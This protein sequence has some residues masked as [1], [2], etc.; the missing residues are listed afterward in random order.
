MVPSGASNN[1]FIITYLGGVGFSDQPNVAIGTN[2][3]TPTPPAVAFS[4][5]ETVKGIN[6]SEQFF[7]VAFLG[8]DGG[9]D[10]P[11]LIHQARNNG[12]SHMLIS[13]L[14][15]GN[16]GEILVNSFL[17]PGAQTLPRIAREP[18]GGF[19]VTWQSANQDGDAGGV[20]AKRFD[21]NG[22]AL[23]GDRDEIQRIEMQGTPAAGSTY[24]LEFA[25]QTTGTINFTRNNIAD[26]LAIQTALRNLP[27][28]G[29]TLT[30]R[31]DVGTADE[32]QLI[33]FSQFAPQTTGGTFQLAHAGLFTG[34]I[35]YVGG[36]AG[37][38]ATNIQ[39]ALRLLP[40]LAAVTVVPVAPPNNE[41]QF[42]VTFTGGTVGGL[43]QPL[44]IVQTENLIPIPQATVTVSDVNDGGRSL[45]NF[46]VEF[47]GVDGKA[48]QPPI[49]LADNTGGVTAINLVEV[50]GGQNSEFLVPE[51]TLGSQAQPA[52]AWQP[53]GNFVTVW[54]S[55]DG[56]AN[57]VFTR[58]WDGAGNPLTPEIQVNTFTQANQQT[59]TVLLDAAGNFV[60]FY[61]GDLQDGSLFGIF[62][63]RFNLDGT[64]LNDEFLVNE[65]TIANQ[66]QPAAALLNPGGD[67]VVS[68][69]SQAGAG[70]IHSRRFSADGT[71]IDANEVQVSQFGTPSQDESVVARNTSGDYV[72]VWRENQKDP[73]IDQGVYA[74]AFFANGTPKTGEIQVHQTTDNN[75]GLPDVA[76]DEA[77]N[78]V[79]T[80]QTT[81]VPLAPAVTHTDILARRFN[82]LGVPQGPEFTVSTVTADN[83]T[84]PRIA[85]DGTGR[86]TIVWQSN[87]QDGSLGGIYAR[88]FDAAGNPLNAQEFRVNT[89]TVGNQRFPAIDARAS[90]EFIVVW[91]S[92]DPNTFETSVFAQRFN[93]AGQ[94]IGGEFAV[95]ATNTSF[96]FNERP[97][98]AF[99][100]AGQFTIAWWDTNG[101]IAARRFDAAA[102]PLTGDILVSDTF[103]NSGPR[104]AS[105]ADGRTTIV[106]T[107][108]NDDVVAQRFTSDFQKIGA[109][110][111]INNFVLGTQR[112]PTVEMGDSGEFLVGWI[113]LGIGG[114][115]VMINSL[116][117]DNPSVG[118]KAAGPQA[119]FTNSLP[120]WVDGSNTQFVGSG[121]STLVIDVEP[122]RQRVFAANLAASQLQER[123][124]ETGVILRTFPMPAGASGDVSLAF[125]GNTLYFASAGSS[126]LFELDPADGAIVDQISLAS[127]GIAGSVG[128]LAHLNGELVVLTPGTGALHFIDT[129]TDE[130]VRSL[131]PGL[132]GALAVAGA[133]SRGTLYVLRAGNQIVEINPTTGTVLGTQ[134]APAAAQPATSLAFVEGNLWVGNAAGNVAVVNPGTNEVQTITLSP[135]TTGGTFTLTF[136][137]QT[138]A[139]ISF[140]GTIP[141]GPA[142]T[143]ANIQAA[144][145]NLS[146]LGETLTVTPVSA[147]VFQVTFTGV[148]GGK[149]QPDITLANNSLLPATPPQTVTI[150]ETVAGAA[151]GLVTTFVAPGP[152]AAL[153]GDDGGAVYRAA[154]SIFQ[155]L[156]D[157][158]LDDEAAISITAGVGPYTGRFRPIE[159]LAGFDGQPVTGTWELR[160]EDTATGNTGLLNDWRLIINESAQT[161]PDYATK[162]FL[163][164]NLVTGANDIDLYRFNVLNPSTLRV[165]LKNGATLDGVVRVFNASGTQIGIGNVIG[166]GVE[167]V[168]VVNL[169]AAGD[170]FIGIS[171]NANTAYSPV[172]GSGATGGL[173]TGEYDLEIRVNDPLAFTDNNSTFADSTVF[174][175][176]G[177]IG[178]TFQSQIFGTRPLLN[179]PGDPTEPGHRDIPLAENH[180]GAGGGGLDFTPNEMLLKFKPGTTPAQ[181]AAL[182]ASNGLV[183][184]KNLGG[185][186]LHLR[187]TSGDVLAK[188]RTLSSELSVQYAEPNYALQTNRIPNDP[189]F[190]E[191]WGMNNIGQ[192]NGQ[193]DSDTDA[194]DA[195]D[196]NTGSSNVVIAVIDTG[197][198]YTHPDLVGNMWRNPGE[199]AGDGVDN[200]ANGFIDDVFGIDTAN[201]DSDPFDNIDHGTH[202]AGTIGAVGDNGVGVAGVAWDVQI[203]ALKFLDV[204]GGD[205]VDAI[206]ALN[207]ITM[208]K[209]TKGINIVASNNS[210]GGGGFSQALQD[211]ILAS[212]NAGI[213]FVASAGND[214]NDNDAFPEFPAS[215]P[216]PGIISVAASDLND[217]LASFNTFGSTFDSNFGATTVDLAAPGVSI[218][219]TTPGNTYSVFH[220]TSMAAPHVTGA[221]ALL[222]SINSSAS[223][224]QIRNAILQGVDPVPALNGLVATGGRLNVGHA[225]Q[226]LGSAVSTLPAITNAFYNFQDFYGV[227]P[228]GD[229]PSNVITET[230]KQR[231]RE[232]FE[233]YGSFLGITFTE[234]ADQGLTVVTGDLRAIDPAVPTG[235][236]GVAGISDGSLAGRVIMDAAENW[237]SSEYGGGWFQVA[238]HEIGHSLGMSHSYDQ[239]SLT[240]M[241][242]Q[243]SVDPVRFPNPGEP[244]FPGD[245][246]LIHGQFLFP[247]GANDIDLYKFTL[248]E[249]GVVTAE[250]IAERL[251]NGSSLL[252]AALTL[253][254]ETT[255]GVTTREVVAQ[256]D[257]YF[258]S[259][260]RIQLNLG[261]GT[262]YVAVTSSGNSDFDPSIADSGFGG[263]SEGTYTLNIS[264][265]GIPN[266]ALTDQTQVPLDGNAD[267]R[268][269]GPFDFWFQSGSTLVV[270][271]MADVGPGPSGTGTL[272]QPFDT[273]SSALDAAGSRIVMPA[274]GAQAFTDGE[275]F[276]I[277]DLLDRLVV[278]EFDFDGL[279]PTGINPI[280]LTAG[281]NAAAV[282]T[283]VAAAINGVGALNSTATATAAGNI[284]RVANFKRLDKSGSDALMATPNLVR[285]VGN[286]GVDGDATNLLDNRPYL[287]GLNNLGQVLPDG[288]DV[289]VPQ[290]ATLM[291]DAGALFKLQ[292]SNF[293]AGS[294]AQGIDRSQGA[295]QVLGTPQTAVYFRSF[296][297]DTAGGDTDGV[298]VGA[299]PGDWG[300]IVFREDSDREGQGVFLNSVIRADMLAG[301]GKL[302]VD[303]VEQTFTPIHLIGARPNIAYNTIQQSAD[304]AISA[305]PNS[306]DDSDDRI[307]PDIHDNRIPNNSINGLFV[308]IRTN[309][310]SPVDRLDVPGRF[311]DVDITHVLSEILIISGTPGGPEIDPTNGLRTPRFDARLRID[312]GIIVKLDGARIETGIGAQLIAEGT[313]NLPVI[314][315]SVKDDTYGAGG[316]FDTTND[317]GASLPEPGQW[318]GLFFAHSAKGSLD[319]VLLTYAGGLTPIEGGFDRFNPIEIHQGIVR[320]TNS[321]FQNN[322]DGQ[323]TSTRN[324]RG[325]NSP[326]TIFVRGAQP[327]I[328]DNVFRNNDGNVISISA[329]ALDAKLHPDYGRSTGPLDRFGQFDD[330]YGPLVRLNRHS[331]NDTSGM[332]VRPAVLTSESVWDDTDIAHVL[333]GEILILNHHTFSGLRLL[334]STNE[335][336]VVKLDGAVPAS[337]P[338]ACRWTSTTASVAPSRSWVSLAGR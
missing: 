206:E 133:G 24:T 159:P 58:L 146:N 195:W 81:I 91:D 307:G 166:V 227:L 204:A 260:P 183:L 65:L 236:G 306:F 158:I 128:G 45:F 225:A 289:R 160:I 321:T 72:V 335:S 80:W 174:G 219:S 74:Q 49:T 48:D 209:L 136:N 185:G 63:R 1:S 64:P 288:A 18:A 188:I 60:V 44:M 267:G 199:I 230:Q 99:D 232:I 221:I 83:Q 299:R 284:V 62:A 122:P 273:L 274:T 165:N 79:V 241:G 253:Y 154:T 23:P 226:L 172:T 35:N 247:Q 157:T 315:T 155:P 53:S 129:F 139:A 148:D 16:N 34:N 251:P 150:V 78:F 193:L 92:Q 59:P 25:G 197:V 328:V 94:P 216:L 124:P 28:L 97:D 38:T 201:D 126:T 51:T 176:L 144:L 316:T 137:G 71:P 330:N 318:G 191:L 278:F 9:R 115:R 192:L 283:A 312:P 67:F 279:T 3:L 269:G 304:A 147:F 246:D 276:A 212:N 292:K 26:A 329:I 257:D 187:S 210:W 170:Y 261:P 308:R 255:G 298:S 42:I 184:I 223:S 338:T 309:L 220:G 119:P 164:D 180:L 286:T 264:L 202:V 103:A 268:P 12:V 32:V 280:P 76:I 215:Y 143:A 179:M 218:L 93:V 303:S 314:F 5:V 77:G 297:D 238:M 68:W 263:R 327:V 121:R 11:L 61:Q 233:I 113:D 134:T 336:L 305:D 325:G 249:P 258:S 337:Q 317:G 175:E 7:D 189:S 168:A 326:A 4:V 323:S 54:I 242:D 110:I 123:D 141:S 252:D 182:L 22:V 291:L 75:Q 270:D 56:D 208:M 245:A 265:E 224:A 313:E 82:A 96:D 320:I 293:D 203:M 167:D 30:V 205:T 85:I 310:G 31:A 86:F 55:P 222:A 324:G 287:L 140:G 114:S 87:L 15:K 116:G 107:S 10:Q 118:I 169:P 46:I 262:Y 135:T 73:L 333:R 196:L 181:Q 132:T 29:N 130:L 125:V 178:L 173:S 228:S 271:K 282:A 254:R 117:T 131:T 84:A 111:T 20:F 285:V 17:L 88:R 275:R 237:G 13:E 200:D 311:D 229:T 100:G 89:T 240:I 177:D 106:W 50:Q 104:I 250:A 272:A 142:A 95:E 36:N 41:F 40:G 213:L 27:N 127:L 108:G 194:S 294:S 8:T 186:T 66:T 207:Y 190:S 47:N 256:N 70:G 211:A 43:D 109:N 234:T 145:R 39:D 244:I 19:V 301:G 162:G 112:T 69:T 296:R 138:T 214:G 331:A 235:P 259:D 243:F 120:I 300:G 37:Q 101:N 33:S 161:P 217:N 21:A 322:D 302:L 98:V 198:D 163:G 102:A 277:V 319:H 156:K 334:S 52:V 248:T 2:N 6:L 231:A 171:S 151:G 281:A 149:V 152:L 105:G 290:A 332:E 57:G 153:G 295:I 14:V 90:G 239:P 266:S